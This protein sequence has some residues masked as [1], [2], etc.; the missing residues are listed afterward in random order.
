MA[1]DTFATFFELSALQFNDYLVGYRNL[2]ETKIGYPGLLNTFVAAVSTDN[3]KI[4]STY[5]TVNSLSDSWE[6]SAVISPLQTAS[7]SWNSNYS[8]TNSNSSFWSNY[9]NYLSTNNVI[10]SSVTV[11]DGLSAL[12]LFLEYHLFSFLTNNLWFFYD[13]VFFKEQ[14]QRGMGM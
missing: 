10:L 4:N 6:E 1:N 11:R 7:A 5:S 8:T 13:M 14:Q 12:L 9:I 2:T 3:E